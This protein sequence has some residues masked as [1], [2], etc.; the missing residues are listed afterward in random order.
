MLY[1]FSG[2]DLSV[3]QQNSQNSPVHWFQVAPSNKS[4]GGKRYS[5]FAHEGQ[6]SSYSTTKCQKLN[7]LF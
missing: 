1:R 5:V 2:H 6:P 7:F 4:Q 3:N